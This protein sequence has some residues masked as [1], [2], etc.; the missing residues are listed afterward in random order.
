MILP[1]SKKRDSQALGGRCGGWNF[2]SLSTYLPINIRL[3]R[4]EKKDGK[5]EQ[6]RKGKQMGTRA[7]GFGLTVCCL[8][9]GKCTKG[10]YL[11]EVRRGAAAY[12][13]LGFSPTCGPRERRIHPFCLKPRVFQI[14]LDRQMW[15]CFAD[16][17]I[18]WQFPSLVA[19]AHSLQISS[20]GGKA[21][22]HSY[23]VPCKTS[24]YTSRAAQ[25]SMSSFLEERA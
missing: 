1:V 18:W 17:L 2:Y 12:W 8:L 13:W 23:F 22:S 16:G 21:R 19:V 10:M 4:G 7:T 9:D 11:L 3:W 5:T 24:T 20:E 6:A 14:Y 25:A 15:H